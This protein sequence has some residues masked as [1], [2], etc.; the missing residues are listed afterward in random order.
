[1]KKILV[2]GS[3]G[4]LGSE[5]AMLSKESTTFEWFFANRVDVSLDNLNL[6]SNQLDTIKA[7]IIINAAAYT[8]VDK[9]ESEAELADVVNH[10][11][12]G[13]IANWAKYNNAKLIHVSTDYVF[14]GTSSAA[15][16]EN[17]HTAPINVYGATKLL[18]E[19]LCLKN[20]SDAII[21][22]TS[23]VYSSFG[24]NFVKT[25]MRLMKER[26]SLNVVNDQIGSPTYAADLAACIIT[27]VS[28]NY[29]ESGIYNYSNEGQISWFDF[30]LA[31]KEIGH[32]DCDLSGIPS[33]A[34]PTPARRPAYSLLD[35][36]KITETFGIIVPN[37]K[38][39]LQ[40]CIYLINNRL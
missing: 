31:I 8:A 36:R 21:I 38:K 14:D 32:F 2:T 13:V 5:L 33:S 22:R 18:G 25:M 29:P 6:L 10:K 19:Q 27:I 1:M 28:N 16:D 12:V 24:N 9:A 40:K 4:Q 39:S 3:T 23:W 20:N 34:Y 26:D 17:A 30:A 15:L 35:K 11:A 37:Y 7:D